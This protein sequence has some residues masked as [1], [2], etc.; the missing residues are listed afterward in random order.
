MLC[1]DCLRQH[2]CWR[3]YIWTTSY[4]VN[5]MINRK[6]NMDFKKV[7]YDHIHK[8]LSN[9]LALTCWCG[10][11]LKCLHWSETVSTAATCFPKLCCSLLHEDI[12]HR[13]REWVH[14]LLGD[15]TQQKQQPNRPLPLPRMSQQTVSCIHFLLFQ[16]WNGRVDPWYQEVFLLHQNTLRWPKYQAGN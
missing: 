9:I 11:L 12:Q 6:C 13:N 1:I 10:N 8:T 15:G 2:F 14:P 3:L 4:T 7:A 16:E 5:C